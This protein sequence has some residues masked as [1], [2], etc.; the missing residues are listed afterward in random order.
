MTEKRTDQLKFAVFMTGDSNYHNAGW[1]L[2]GAYNDAGLRLDRW[3]EFAQ[4]MERGKL[5]MLF[6]ADG[7]GTAGIDNLKATRANPKVDRMEPFTLLSALASVTKHIG[8][9]ATAHTTYNEPYHIARQFASLDHLSGGRA[10]WNFVTGA[11]AED[12]KNFSRDSHQVHGDR[13]DRAEEFADVCIGLW[14]SYEDDAFKRDKDTGVY[15]D[16]DKLHVLNHKGKYF[17]V[18]GPLSVARPPQG[19][20]VLIQA[21]MSEPARELSARVA[22]AVFTSQ[23]TFE[24]AHAFYAD[25]KNRMDKY[26]RNPND[27]K[28]L[29]GVAIFTGRT[30][31]EAEEKYEALSALVNPAA[32][33]ALLGARTGIDLTGVPLDEPVPELKGNDVRVSNPQLMFKLA[34]REKLTLRGLVQRYAAAGPHNMVRGTPSQ[35][36]DQLEYWFLNRAADGFIFLPVYLPGA[37]ND[38]V[39]M[40]VPELQRR[41]LFR[42]EYEGKTLRENMGLPRPENV[43]LKR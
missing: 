6:I 17:Q 42:K 19:H 12:A 4:T 29:P 8:L 30:A 5:D 40:I 21:G 34:Q 43:F 38:F 16:T 28:I 35:V 41:G 11:N 14:D 36:A 1:R 39:D 26:G 2:P 20:P 24:E 18:K 7:I 10:G 23:P 25:I 37:L 3:I 31:E 13:Y 32:A 9:A 33:V 15:V 27:L 22:D